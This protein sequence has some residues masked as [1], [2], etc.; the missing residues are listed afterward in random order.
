MV[1]HWY[2]CSQLLVGLPYTALYNSLA[3]RILQNN[4]STEIPAIFRRTIA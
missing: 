4:Q 3:T 1:I 2:M